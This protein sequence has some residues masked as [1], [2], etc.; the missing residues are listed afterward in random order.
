MFFILQDWPRNNEKQ[1]KVYE[2]L[3]FSKDHLNTNAEGGKTKAAIEYS[4]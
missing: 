3:L 1:V 4:W 2:L